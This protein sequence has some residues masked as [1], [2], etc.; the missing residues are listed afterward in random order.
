M[1][2]ATFTIPKAGNDG[3][4]FPKTMMMEI[5]RDLLEMFEGYTAREVSGG[6]IEKD[7]TVYREDNWEYTVALE[8]GRFRELV[9]W[10]RRMKRVL[11]QKAMYL[12]VTDAR[13]RFL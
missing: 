11:K 2:I 8:E 1:K 3:K 6:W 13:V 5:Q 4:K 9:T 10:L 7:G 12:E